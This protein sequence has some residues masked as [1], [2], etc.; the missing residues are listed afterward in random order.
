MLNLF[1]LAGTFA[2][3]W[4]V[5][6]Y[7]HLA[8]SRGW[9]IGELFFNHNNKLTFW[10]LAALAGIEFIAFDRGQLWWLIVIPLVGIALSF[11]LTTVLKSMVQSV[12]LLAFILGVVTSIVFKH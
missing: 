9:P 10:V 6:T 12:G 3:G 1:I 4:S 11:I 2:L 8:Q 5:F 7:K